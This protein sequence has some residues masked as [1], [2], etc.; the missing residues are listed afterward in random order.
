MPLNPIWTHYCANHLE[1]WLTWIRGVHLQSYLE[2]MDRFI[3]SHP[4][5]TPD[6]ADFSE[7]TNDLFNRLIANRDFIMSL[8]DK[9]LSVWAN[10]GFIDF[11]DALEPYGTRYREI[12]H[13]S[14]FL[15]LHENWFR[16]LYQFFRADIIMYLREQGRNL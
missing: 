6:E 10:S 4:F 14:D 8:S 11:L 15:R 12:R 9:G 7:E 5:Y 3:R 16:R 1:G 2:L 13:L